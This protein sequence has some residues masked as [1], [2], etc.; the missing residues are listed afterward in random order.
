MDILDS[1]ASLGVVVTALLLTIGLIRP[2]FVVWWNKSNSRKQ[3]IMVWGAL[4]MF[5]VIMY[6]FVSS[7]RHDNLKGSDTENQ[8]IE[9]H[10]QD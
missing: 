6:F 5:F 3:V 1:I 4:F 7:Y 2:G 9:V 8:E 10:S